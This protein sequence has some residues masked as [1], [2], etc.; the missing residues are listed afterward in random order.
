MLPIVVAA[1]HL[2]EL[3]GEKSQQ[4]LQPIADIGLT[5]DRQQLLRAMGV[6]PQTQGQQAAVIGVVQHA[7]PVY[8]MQRRRLLNVQLAPGVIAVA[9]IRSIS[10]AQDV[11]ECRLAICCVLPQV[12]ESAMYIINLT[13]FHMDDLPRS[14]TTDQGLAGGD[15][16]FH[17]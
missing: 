3:T 17:M 4:Q 2:P 7:V 1:Q 10:R 13:G 12:S 6:L 14:M 15:E 11:E 16:R 9:K 8:D 5:V